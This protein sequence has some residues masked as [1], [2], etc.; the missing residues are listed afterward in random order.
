MVPPGFDHG[1][2]LLHEPA[3]D[4][5]RLAID[6]TQESRDLLERALRRGEA[7]A[8]RPV[9]FRELVEPLEREGEM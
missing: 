3:I 8:L 9:A 6:P 2:H 4:D 5:A 1:R 7:D